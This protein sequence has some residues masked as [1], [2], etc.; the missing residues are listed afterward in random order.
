[1]G[2]HRSRLLVAG[3]AGLA[4]G[5]LVY[6]ELYVP[7]GGRTIAFQTA[8]IGRLQLHRAQTEVFRTHS[9]YRALV[10]RLDVAVD[11][12]HIDLGRNTA[13]LIALGPRSSAGSGVRIVRV[14]E[15]RGRVLVVASEDY[16]PGTPAVVSYPLVVVVFREK[17]KPIV[18]HW[19]N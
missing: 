15:Q 5:W 7:S 18:V 17:G 4:V 6:A 3:L 14:E 8:T 12:P 2:H 1:M 11:A 16:R 19:D 13:V 10:E 9:E